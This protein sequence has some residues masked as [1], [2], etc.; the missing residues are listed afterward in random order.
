[1]HIFDVPSNEQNELHALPVVEQTINLVMWDV[2]TESLSV[3]TLL[4]RLYLCFLLST[5]RDMRLLER[6][7]WRGFNIKTQTNQMKKPIQK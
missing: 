2:R 3:T 6:E 5:L 4:R 7:D 1:L